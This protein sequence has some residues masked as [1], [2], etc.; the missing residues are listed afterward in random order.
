VLK[1]YD[2]TV[3]RADL[4]VANSRYIAGL[5]ERFWRVHAE[6]VYPTLNL[7][8]AAAPENDPKGYILF[9]KPQKA[10]GLDVFLGLAAMLPDRR[11]AVAGE[12]GRGAAELLAGCR[13]VRALG[14]Q[15]DMAGVYRRA[16]LVVVPSALPEPFGRVAAEAAGFGVPTVSFRQGGVPEAAGAGGAFLEPGASGNEWSAAIRELDDPER[17]EALRRGALEN[18]RRIASEGGARRVLA[19][20]EEAARK[21]ARAAPEPPQPGRRLK[22]VHVIS[23]LPVGGAE[24]S[25]FHLVSRLDR[26]RFEPLVVCTR[27]EDAMAPEF[28]R[29]GV[30]VELVRLRSRYGPA[31]LLRL[32][33]FLRREGADIVHTHMRRA[34]TSG[35]LAAWLARVPVIVAHERSPGPDKTRIHFLVDRWLSRVSDAILAVSPDT[36]ERNA[37]LSGIPRERFTVLP[38][39]VD[40]AEFAPGDRA[41]ARAALGLPAGDFVVGFA[42]RLHPVKRL[43]VLVRAAAAAAGEVA[44]LRLVLAGSGPERERLAALAA[45]LGIA[46]RTSFLGERADMP[47]VYPAFDLLCLPSES[48]GCS[49]VL[50]EAAAA[51]LPLVATAVGYAAELI[52]ADE[53]GVLVPPGDAGAL[54]A[55]LVRLA[56]EP[57]TRTRMGAAARA[58]VAGH[59]IDEYVRKVERLYARLWAE[60]ADKD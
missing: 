38:N 56:R 32:A 30:R 7:P 50:L 59:G 36:A 18:A 54:A 55:A 35:R 13:N 25:L 6:V 33:R 27:A 10:K 20:L 58:R 41:A 5:L 21:G 12:L 22:V 9:V 43:D 24:K 48:E 16:R 52:G 2:R 14:W 19:L 23:A 28:R 47:A 29:A 44:N 3:P 51:G 17:Y 4:I 53:A 46:A 8:V 37:R 40:L 49:R 15:E 39:A 57:E 45:E 60:R 34:N 31:S 1:L 26:A 42:G 11:F